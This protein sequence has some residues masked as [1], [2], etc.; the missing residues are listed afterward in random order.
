M[1]PTRMVGTIFI[2]ICA[3]VMCSGLVFEDLGVAQMP[4]V[5]GCPIFLTKFFDRISR[6]W[7][8]EGTTT[9]FRPRASRSPLPSWSAGSPTSRRRRSP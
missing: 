3:I 7:K 4:V 1:G 2:S 6:R 9:N 5:G 8:E